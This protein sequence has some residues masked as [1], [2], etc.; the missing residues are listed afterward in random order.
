MYGVIQ[1]WRHW[2]RGKSEGYTNMVAKITKG[3]VTH[4]GFCIDHLFYFF[5]FKKL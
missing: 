1:K 2:G 3:D 5:I 4:Y